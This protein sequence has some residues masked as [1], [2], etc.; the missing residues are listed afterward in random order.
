MEILSEQVRAQLR[1][2]ADRSSLLAVFA[3]V[4]LFSLSA[5]ARE[6]AAARYLRLGWT[7]ETVLAQVAA[8]HQPRR[9][10]GRVRDPA[11]LLRTT[12]ERGPQATRHRHAVAVGPAIADAARMRARAQQQQSLEQSRWDELVLRHS[13]AYHDFPR[14]ARV[15]EYNQRRAAILERIHASPRARELLIELERC[16][17]LGHLGALCELHP[18]LGAP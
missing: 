3:A 11:A 18:E 2:G 17:T 6:R 5:A 9:G 15:Q 16:P 14:R 8:I 10:E 4:G 13:L 1:P 12:L 7:T